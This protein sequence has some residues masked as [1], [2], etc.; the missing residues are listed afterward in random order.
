MQMPHRRSVISRQKVHQCRALSPRCSAETQTP[1]NADARISRCASKQ[2]FQ[3]EPSPPPYQD[4]PSQ[5]N[6][7]PPLRLINSHRPLQLLQAL[8]V[9]IRVGHERL[10]PPPVGLVVGLLGGGLARFAVGRGGVACCDD[11]CEGWDPVGWVS[12]P[13]RE[14]SRRW[15]EKYHFRVFP[16]VREA[17]CR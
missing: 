15:G 17:L 8:P 13:R 16:R 6:S 2:R 1:K 9:A 3:T 5:L 4:S 10:P 7:F 14:K 11:C 12:S